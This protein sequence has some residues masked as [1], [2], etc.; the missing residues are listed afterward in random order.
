MAV[1]CA[2]VPV[3]WPVL[4]ATGFQIF[5]TKE[6]QVTS[7]ARLRS[8]DVT[9]EGTELQYTGFNGQGSSLDRVG[10]LRSKNGS[11]VS[12]HKEARGH[13]RNVSSFGY[14]KDTYD[15]SDGEDDTSRIEW[16]RPSTRVNVSA[17]SHSTT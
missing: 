3:F 14:G 8:V 10:S 17:N 1:V 6:V 5:I 11:E 7:E 9:A 15:T 12:L 13:V 4:Q 2:S 16:M